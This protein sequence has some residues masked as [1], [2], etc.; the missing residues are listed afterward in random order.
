MMLEELSINYGFFSLSTSLALTYKDTGVYG[1]H[2][3]SRLGLQRSHHGRQ[4][5]RRILQV[6]HILLSFG[7]IDWYGGPGYK[8]T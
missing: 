3:P 8:L 7:P 1:L 4:F 6:F 2:V 5:H